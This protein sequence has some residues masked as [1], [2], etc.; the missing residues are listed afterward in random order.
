MP[1]RL[2][3]IIGITHLIVTNAAGGLNPDYKIGDIMILKDHLNMMGFA[4]NSA[5]N[6]PNDE[7]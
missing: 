3:K 6:G 2:M 5:L 7:R 1:V 4:G